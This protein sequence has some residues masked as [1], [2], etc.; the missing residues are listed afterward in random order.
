MAKA[1]GVRVAYANSDAVVY[2]IRAPHTLAPGWHPSASSGG[3]LSPKTAWQ[4]GELA[5]FALALMLFAVRELIRLCLPRWHRLLR[6]LAL[7]AVPV[8]VLLS[9]VVIERFVV[10]S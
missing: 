10:L 2:A 6:P 5:V 8:L 7:A 1:P 9:F 3:S 4:A